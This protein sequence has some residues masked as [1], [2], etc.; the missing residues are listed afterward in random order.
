MKSIICAIIKD[1]Q[2]F[3]KE[4]VE[5]YLSIGFDKLYIFEDY[6]STSHK[7]IL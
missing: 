7:K 6:G 1:E 2:R 3:I 5:Y 4:W